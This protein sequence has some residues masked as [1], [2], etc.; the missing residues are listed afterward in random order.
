[1]I[2]IYRCQSKGIV[3]QNLFIVGYTAYTDEEETCR[4]AGMDYFSKLAR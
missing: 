4:A 3:E 1:M 2:T